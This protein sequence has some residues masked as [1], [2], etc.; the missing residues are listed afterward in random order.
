MKKVLAIL[1]A[2]AM[3]LT[4]LAGCSGEGG[5]SSSTSGSAASETE[6]GETAQEPVGEPQKVVFA[7][8]TFNTVPTVEI[9][10]TVADEVNS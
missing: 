1:L 4:A 5:A 8:Q 9:S 7:M 2:M 6:S 10:Q 3:C